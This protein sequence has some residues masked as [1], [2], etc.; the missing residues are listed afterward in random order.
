MPKRTVAAAATGLPNSDP[1]P[2]LTDTER[3]LAVS[4][5]KSAKALRPSMLSGEA[6]EDF[7]AKFDSFISS[8][9]ADETGQPV[10][11]MSRPTVLRKQI[12]IPI[13]TIR[14]TKS[15][16]LED[17]LFKALVSELVEPWRCRRSETV[18]HSI[19]N[20]LLSAGCTWRAA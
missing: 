7:L 13:R 1:L 17:I 10:E 11:Y 5:L 18:A 12:I 16:N 20:D 3:G 6:L 8:T 14:T 15:K 9:Q 2:I 19:V 4:R